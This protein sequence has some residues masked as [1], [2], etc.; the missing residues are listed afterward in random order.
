MYERLLACGFTKQMAKDI[1]TLF[2]DMDELKTYV[3]FVE[4]FCV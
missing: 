4:M 1:I 3:Y 2:P